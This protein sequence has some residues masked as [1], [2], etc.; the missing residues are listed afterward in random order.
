MIDVGK[1]PELIEAVNQIINNGKVA[2]IKKEQGGS[3]VTVVEQQ[4]ALRRKI[5]IKQN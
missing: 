2:E 4:R 1:L 3:A 5:E